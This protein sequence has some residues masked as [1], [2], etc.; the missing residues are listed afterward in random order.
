MRAQACSSPDTATLATR[1]LRCLATTPTP[2]A[3]APQAEAAAAQRRREEAAEARLAALRSADL[4]SYLTLLK[5]AKNSRL[6]E[7]LRQTDACLQQL[8]AKLG[9]AAAAGARGGGGGTAGGGEEQ[10]QQGGG[11]GAGASDAGRAEVA[12]SHARLPGDC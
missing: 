3:A 4:P 9:G 6:Q 11:A 7:V 12:S 2:G 1:L 10:Q 8:A 5:Q